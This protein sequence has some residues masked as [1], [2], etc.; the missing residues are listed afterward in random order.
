MSQKNNFI[1]IDTEGK[2]ELNEIAIVNSQGQLI[3]EAFAREYDAHYEIQLNRKP[4]QQ[5]VNDFIQIAQNKLVICHSAE[6]D[7]RVLKNSFFRVKIDWQNFEFTCTYKLARKYFHNLSSYSLEYL[8][9]KLNLKV[10]NKYFNSEQAH[11][12]RYDTEFTYQLYQKIMQQQTL[13]VAKNKTNPF[14]S[15]RVDTP[16]QNHPDLTS[17]YQNQFTTLKTIID[18]IK[19]DFNHQTKG[20]VVIG[21]PGTGKTHLMM[22]LANELLEQ[23]RLL[24][25]RQPN[26]SNTVIYHTY[27]RI[28]ESLVE[29]V[30]QSGYTQ[31]EYLLSNSFVKLI[32]S[33]FIVS[34][35]KKD[36]DILEAT[37][38]K[39][40]KL[41]DILGKEGTQNKRKSWEYIERI[42]TEWWLKRYGA[43]GYSLEIIKGIIKFCAYSDA[44]Y[45]RLVTR[46]LAADNLEEDELNKIG[47]SNWNEEMS[48][49]AFSLE[50]IAVLS[51]FSL[52]DEPLIIVFD[53][54]EGLGLAHNKTLLQKFGEAIKEIF[55]HV[56]NSLI[57]LN[58]FP[59]RWQQF[60]QVFDN[61]IVD[62]ISQNKVIL[63]NPSQSE[64]K[65]ILQI[66]A[67]SVGIDLETL[68]T[69]EELKDIINQNSIR[70]VLNRAYDYYRF[71]V[72][73]VALAK[74]TSTETSQQ[75][76]RSSAQ[77]LQ[78]LENQILQLQ[79]GLQNIAQ[80]FN[81]LKRL[82]FKV[83]SIENKQTDSSSHH[84]ALENTKKRA[85]SDLHQ[86]SN[87][88]DLRKKQKIIK[89]LEREKKQLE[90][91]YQRPQIVEDSDDIGKLRTIT[92][93]FKSINNLEIDHLRLGK[94]KL[95]EHLAIENKSNK[96]CIGFL[97]VSNTSFTARIKN[98]NSLVIEHKDTNFL[99]LRDIRQ[100]AITG[101]TGKEEIAKLNHADNGEFIII[102]RENRI[103][104]ELIYKAI[105]DLQN[106][107]LDLTLETALPILISY[108]QNYWLTKILL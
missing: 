56:P 40:L 29:E 87:T 55:T 2:N 12:A 48:K 80:E 65:Q 85:K 86:P 26:N 4:L 16:F 81:I 93:A 38:D 69:S 34:P 107:D 47:L 57:I 27:S 35:N 59:D 102:G 43:A 82:E 45:K 89:Y 68:F 83:K 49:E 9:K 90:D 6:H 13:Q 100:S 1:V 46:W 61:S 106:K 22:R 8:S 60:Q 108:F 11:T 53:Q 37:T 77:V 104:F 41:Y 3:Y 98:W 17:I 99:L 31:L 19:N 30:G 42:T 66:K 73:G 28:L 39:A 64:L 75:T 18:E 79:Q 84:I 70:G 97:Q 74:K 54:L 44:N 36:R 32:K 94:K 96:T 10:N 52:L 67:Q 76:E 103:S 24:F 15:S 92:E 58:L 101:K 105:V 20:A 62:R 71:R 78:S 33:Y 72:Y 91:K 50:A 51:K 63:E 5:I 21:E 88:I 7:L 14:S 95:P 25:I 23:N